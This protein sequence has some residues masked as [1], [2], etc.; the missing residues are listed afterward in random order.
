MKKF[1]KKALAVALSATIA[2]AG[3]A[4]L[5]A[6]GGGDGG[7]YSYSKTYD[8]S[9]KGDIPTDMVNQVMFAYSES[10]ATVTAKLTLDEDKTEYTLY[11]SI[12]AKGDAG[13]GGMSTVFKGEYEFYGTYD[14]DGSDA[15]KVTLKIPTSGKTNIWYPTALNYQ[16]IEKQTQ[17][18]VTSADRPEL[19]TRFNK[20][21][22]AKNAGT[23]DQPVTLDGKTLT[24]GD[25]TI[26]PPPSDDDDDDDDNEG[27]DDQEP[28]MSGW[29]LDDNAL[30]AVGAGGKALNFYA[31][32]TAKVVYPAYSL[33][34][35]GTWA[36]STE[37]QTAKVTLVLG[38]T[39]YDCPLDGTSI[40]VEW[41][42][43]T[44]SMVKETFVLTYSN[45]SKLMNN[46]AAA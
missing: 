38:G 24:F 31:D 42:C 36:W 26:T 27:G 18:W 13:D 33:G 6:C 9:N 12:E 17:D 25:V 2:C 43:S 35:E 23:V 19:L 39:E 37:G 32:G 21:Y 40:T 8:A 44:V 4:A 20:W 15:K 34:D 29:G 28:D 10:E 30:T 46:G 16:S 11:K 1:I 14:V 3:A 22:P 45:W 7:T 5:V 41:T